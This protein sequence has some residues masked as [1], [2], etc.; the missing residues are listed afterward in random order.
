MPL[1]VLVQN[2]VIPSFW[3]FGKDGTSW[4]K[5]MVEKSTHIMSQEAKR[6]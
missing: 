1:E 3:A 4:Q 2:Q 5:H 6:D